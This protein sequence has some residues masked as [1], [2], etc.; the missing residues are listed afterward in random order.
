MGGMHAR[1]AAAVAW[2]PAVFASAQLQPFTEEAAGRGV[3]YTP[4]ADG[5]I[6]SGAGVGFAD[7]DGDGFPD[8]IAMG[9]AEG[10]VGI[11]ENDGSGSFIDRTGATGI[12][13]LVKGS[14]F[15][16][17]DFDADGDLDLAISKWGGGIHLFRNDGAFSFVDIT[18]SA[19]LTEFAATKGLSW[20]DVD[21]DGWIDL[22]VCNYVNGIPGTSNARNRL[23]RNNGNGTFTDKSM[24]WGV[25]A[26]AYS[27]VAALTDLDQDG[28]L[29]IYLSNDRGMYFPFVPNRHWRN[30]GPGVLTEVGQQD[31]SGVALFSMGLA[32]GDPDLDGRIDLYCTNLPSSVPPLNGQ[33]PLLLQTTPGQWVQAQQQWGVSVFASGWGTLLFDVDRDGRE[34]LFV[35]NLLVP[36]I[37]FY[38]TGAPPMANLTASMGLSG[39]TTHGFSASAADIDSD[40][41][42]D[43]VVSHVGVN[44]QLYVNHSGA[45]N[46][47]AMFTLRGERHD[48]QGIGSTVRV[49]TGAVTQIRQSIVGANG[50]LGQND[51]RLH[52]GLGQASVMDEIFVDWPYTGSKRRLINYP[53]DTVWT[54]YPPSELGDVDH[55]GSIDQ[56]DLSVFAVNCFHPLAPGL[57]ML[58]MNGDALLDFDDYLLLVGVLTGSVGDFDGDGTVGGS[59]L[60]FVLDAWGQGGT[61]YDLN[62][63]GI[64][65]GADLAIVLGNWG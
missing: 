5:L 56:Q 58:D 17:G 43:L 27:F 55:D 9:S 20:G 35:V 31:G 62:L 29:D 15:S 47:W 4:A 45:T 23:W 44:I 39:P 65:N 61:A 48:L 25:D 10:R 42:L 6:I 26:K 46:H 30:D 3:I 28:D 24:L 51:G 50:Y 49:H 64:V 40:G 18:A 12:P 11:F 13:P 14:A 36:N 32:V 1:V 38:N 53:A 21:G 63:D 33:N 41:D 16:A 37:L 19:G 52:F 54:L 7:L 60:A 2:A 22:Y 34:D 8:L 57:E 59:D